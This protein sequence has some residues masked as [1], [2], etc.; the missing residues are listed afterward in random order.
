MCMIRDREELEQLLDAEIQQLKHKRR[1][2]EELE[3]RLSEKYKITPGLIAD[4]SMGS[5]AWN[6]IEDWELCLI[7]EVT[8]QVSGSITVSPINFYHPDEIEESKL[9][10]LEP[11][12]SHELLPI[13]LNDV[14]MISPD[15]YIT[16]IKMTD[17]VKWF[18]ANLI[19]YDYETQRSAKF[20]KKGK[21]GVV[22]T[23]DVNEK[24]VKEIAQH[25]LSETYLTDTVTLNVYSDE[26][27]PLS[28]NAKSKSLTV[29]KGAVVSILDGFHRLQAGTRAVSVN[30]DLPQVMQL[31]IK[32]YDTEKAKKYFGQINTI[33]VV[34]QQRLRE[35]KQEKLSDF[36]VN[37]LKNKSDLE[38]RIASSDQVSTVAKQLTT[39]SILSDAIDA[40]FEMGSRKDAKEVSEY[41][42]EFFTELFGSFKEEFLDNQDTFRKTSYIND[43]NMFAG[44]VVLAKRF[45]DNNISLSKIE[46]VI[47]SINFSKEGTFKDVYARN[48]V[49]DAKRK[50]AKICEFFKQ[51]D[52]ESIAAIK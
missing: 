20:V 49:T 47:K 9:I 17:L 37:E 23:P 51:L 52:L 41:L 48:R 36:V 5:K 13:T 7:A 31:S 25:F 44:Y 33:H 39:F 35:L 24:H 30:P 26:V 28:Y 10:A 21:A 8:S 4:I 18:N 34:K 32:S 3:N 50:R 22:P 12:N 6:E 42:G 15:E 19:Y 2:F 16:K 1:D 40:E 11:K 29:N 14:L 46:D 45:Q 27:T 43:Q 38:G